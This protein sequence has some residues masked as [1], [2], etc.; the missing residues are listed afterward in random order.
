MPAPAWKYA[1]AIFQHGASQR[2]ARIDIPIKSEVADRPCVTAASGLFQFANDLHCADFRRA[3]DGAGG[4]RRLHQIEC[5]AIGPAQT[6][7]HV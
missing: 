1:R 3:G 2:D 6:P 5:S 7:C 4:K